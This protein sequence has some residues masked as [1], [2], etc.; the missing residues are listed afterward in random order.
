MI[1]NLDLLVERIK[2]SCNSDIIQSQ[3]K[4]KKFFTEI[5]KKKK[6]NP[7]TFGAHR[8]GRILKHNTVRHVTKNQN[9]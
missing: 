5:E 1:R 8:R 4:Y 3:S 6:N 7:Q 9:K 2:M